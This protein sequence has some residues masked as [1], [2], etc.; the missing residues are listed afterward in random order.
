MRPPPGVGRLVRQYHRKTTSSPRTPVNARSEVMSVKRYTLPPT[1]RPVSGG[2]GP[3]LPVPKG[4]AGGGGGDGGLG[5]AARCSRVFKSESGDGA[6]FD[7]GGG[8]AAGRLGVVGSSSVVRRGAGTPPD[9]RGGGVAGKRDGMVPFRKSTTRGVAMAGGRGGSAEGAGFGGGA[10]AIGG[11]AAVAVPRC[12]A[13][14]AATP[15]PLCFFSYTWA[16]WK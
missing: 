1:P 6:S 16:I 14:L 5:G 12:G 4:R 13:A 10:V 8:G 3:W 15:S 11:G 2:R 9:V 7:G